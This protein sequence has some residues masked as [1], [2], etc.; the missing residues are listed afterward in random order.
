MIDEEKIKYY[1][2]REVRDMLLKKEKRV[3]KIQQ[4][5]IIS[6]NWRYSSFI[7]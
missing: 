2:E 7:I 3:T 4:G 6:C 1:K 5:S